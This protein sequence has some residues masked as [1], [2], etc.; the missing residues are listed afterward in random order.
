MLAGL[1]VNTLYVELAHHYM[2]G[3]T[4]DSCFCNPK[5]CDMM[6]N[7]MDTMT[8]LWIGY[9]VEWGSWMVTNELDLLIIVCVAKQVKEIEEWARW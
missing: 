2:F 1:S 5:V 7:V 8:M 6:T 4:E 9:D 3:T